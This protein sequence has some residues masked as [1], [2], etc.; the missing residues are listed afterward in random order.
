MK[1][2]NAILTELQRM[3]KGVEDHLDEVQK[4]GYGSTPKP[5]A[6]EDLKNIGLELQRFLDKHR[7]THKLNKMKR[8]LV[9]LA[10]IFVQAGDA[11]ATDNLTLRQLRD[12]AVSIRTKFLPPVVDH[13]GSMEPEEPEPVPEKATN[14]QHVNTRN[15]WSRERSTL[16]R[17]P[18]RGPYDVIRLPVV[19]VFENYKA[20]EVKAL[21]KAGFDVV[22]EESAAVILNQL[23]LVFDKR[24]VDKT[25]PTNTKSRDKLYNIQRNSVARHA[26]S[27][28]DDLGELSNRSYALM[29][30]NASL[31]ERNPNLAM[32]WFV[33]EKQRARLERIAPA[34][35]D[36]WGFP[37]SS[38]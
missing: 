11:L 28:L 15:N 22:P 21:E 29:G 23:V 8:D 6:A 14:V 17:Q 34:K 37:W 10:N 35:V 25:A 33:P 20:G 12:V 3:V 31:S 7:Q 2:K 9:K 19:A 38:L 32:F 18:P 13:V 24:K 16:P 30:L 27:L 1:I 36:Q 5:V 4:G 26:Q